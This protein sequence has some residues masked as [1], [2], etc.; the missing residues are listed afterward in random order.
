MHYS[1]ALNAGMSG[2]P[3][4]DAG[5][6]V[7]GVNVAGYRGSQLVAF[8]VPAEHVAALVARAGAAPLDVGRAREE[9]ARQLRAHSEALLAAV[10]ARLR[11][12][13]HHGY[14][15]PAQPA[16]FVECRAGSDP[17]PEQPVHVER[18]TCNAKSA[19]YLGRD[20]HVGGL[21]FEHQVLRTDTLDA[22]RFSHRL[23]DARRPHQGFGPARHLAP[24]ACT[25]RNVELS[26]FTANATLCLRAY[27]K[28]DGV[29]DLD[30]HVV[31]KNRA[32]RGFVS[33]L[34]LTGVSAERALAFA[35]TYLEAD[36]VLDD[37]HVAPVHV[38]L[39]ADAEGR[40]T[41]TDLDSL[42]GIEVGGRRLRGGAAVP[43]TDGTL[44]VGR[45]RLRVRTA[46]EVL[47][48]EQADASGAS[49]LTQA[50]ERKALAAAFALGIAVSV[51][52][53]WTT[54]E[55]PRELAT[56]LVTAL[57]G[58]MVAAGLWIALWRSPAGWRSASRAGSGTR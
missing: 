32:T 6:Q 51:L 2:G 19:I 13:N 16:G 38:R 43:L 23:E 25:Q 34:S 56:A 10:G 24:F 12:Q 53:V 47:A 46:A 55:Q 54:T 4:L 58:L 18:V 40:V 42:N 49:W 27:R 29:Y 1:G 33:S 31:S 5:G 28:L 14:A 8:L 26:G 44:R 52:E 45:T 22:W 3:G 15:L 48:P 39:A 50:A 37:S 9:I 21:V 11:T 20:L 17:A 41:A 30:L 57:L 7:I 36:V 35:R